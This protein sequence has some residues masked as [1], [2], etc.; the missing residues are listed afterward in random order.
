MI[1]VPRQVWFWLA[2]AIAI[3]LALWLLHGILPDPNRP[4]LGKIL[5]EGVADA[6]KS[7]GDLVRQGMG[8]LAA[9]LRSPWSG[10]QALISFFSLAVVIPVVA[11]YLI[12]RRHRGAPSQRPGARATVDAGPQI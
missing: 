2:T 7:T 12:C 3:G 11:F 4:W 1:A 8:W 6:T 9:F 5:G 10:R